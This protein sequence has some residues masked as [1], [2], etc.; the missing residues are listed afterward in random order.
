MNRTTGDELACSNLRT[1]PL[2]PGK[3]SSI[4]NRFIGGYKRWSANA[5]AGRG[6]LVII[7]CRRLIKCAKLL[8]TI[9]LCSGPNQGQLCVLEKLPGKV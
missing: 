8:C 5:H 9:A 2:V 7:A 4:L 6:P 1:E 3:D